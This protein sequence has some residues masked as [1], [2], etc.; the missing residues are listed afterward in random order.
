M[1]VQWHLASNKRE[2]KHFDAFKLIN[3]WNRDSKKNRCEIFVCK[4]CMMNERCMFVGVLYAGVCVCVCVCDVCS[5]C[6]YDCF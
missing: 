6:A 1:N 2:K 3:D 5:V 4:L